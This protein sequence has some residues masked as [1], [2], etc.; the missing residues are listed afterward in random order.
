MKKL[1]I[2][3]LSLFSSIILAQR[4]EMP[5][6]ELKEKLDSI[7]REGN[8]LYKYEKA[9]WISNDLAFKN[10]IVKAEF[11]DYVTY[12]EQGEIK[13]IIFEEKLQTCIAEYAFENNFDHPKSVKI[14]KRQLS[15]KEKQLINVREKILKNIHDNEYK[16]IIPT[17]GYSLNFILLPFSDKYK[18]YI[19]TGTTE[20]NIVPFGNDY[21]FIANENGEIENWHKFHSQ[22]IPAS[23]I[24]GGNNVR[25][26]NAR[27][28]RITGL[29][30]THL[31]STPLITPTD[32]CTFMLYAP[33]YDLETLTVL[34]A[35]VAMKYSLKENTIKIEYF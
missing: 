13:T 33:L 10:P 7:L 27:R 4:L 26:N 35:P 31:P 22:L 30:H 6:S 3:L 16:V 24:I 5:E 15:D 34:Y 12:E 19:I 17:K 9:A 11:H 29:I 8:L 28:N 1:L 25:R 2:V 20:P 23:T 21:I 32:I 14:E 18:L